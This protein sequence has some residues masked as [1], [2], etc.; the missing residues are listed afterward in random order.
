MFV[1]SRLFVS[2]MQLTSASHRALLTAAAAKPAQKL[3][4]VLQHMIPHKSF[5][6]VRSSK[7]SLEQQCQS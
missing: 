2:C 4:S 6:E 1:E 7:R 3:S 5:L